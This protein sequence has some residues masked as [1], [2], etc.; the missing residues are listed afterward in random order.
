MILKKAF[1]QILNFKKVST[2]SWATSDLLTPLQE[3]VEELHKRRKDPVLMQKVSEYLSHDIPS[4]FAKGPILYLARHVATPNFETLRFLHL[5]EPIGIPPVIGQDPS[6]KFVS[7]NQLKRALC[8]LPISI[9][10]SMKN[11]TCHEN[12]E[13]VSIVDFKKADGKQFG[14]IETLW[15]GNL[16]EFHNSL[17]SALT[18]QEVEIV[19][20][21]AWIDRQHRG[22]LYLH[23]KK[24]L[25][26]FVVHGV[27][28][29][30]YAIEDREEMIFIEKVLRP[31][32]EAIE[33]QFG[34]KP[35]IA[36]LTPTTVESPE[37]W[38]SY[39][40]KVLDII[41]QYMPKTSNLNA[42]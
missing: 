21:S 34:C 26:L 28:F 20:D 10:A 42:V 2:E 39:P 4:H 19:D 12:I 40:K 5:V 11:G 25:A 37:F 13:R 31:A 23:Y 41:R 33:A 16:V 8:K 38:I 6:D 24:F 7:K 22:D 1:S 27:L 32:Y 14:N 29:E 9:C 30:D 15:G 18:K 36:Q 17:F 35:L 3:A